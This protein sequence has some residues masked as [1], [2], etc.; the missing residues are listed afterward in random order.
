MGEAGRAGGRGGAGDGRSTRRTGGDARGEGEGGGDGAAQRAQQQIQRQLRHALQPAAAGAKKKSGSFDWMR[1]AAAASSC[2]ARQRSGPPAAPHSRPAPQ[3]EHRTALQTAPVLWHAE[4]RRGAEA[5]LRD[6]GR[7][8]RGE[9]HH[10]NC[11]P[12]CRADLRRLLA[13]AAGPRR[14]LL[15]QHRLDREEDACK[16]ASKQE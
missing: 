3:L 13:R 1:L 6:H 7:Q 12:R 14:L 5:G 4:S 2:G 11:E 9:Q 15:L 8:H 10:G 16:R